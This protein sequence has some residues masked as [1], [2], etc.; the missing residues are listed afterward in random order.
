MVT[1]LDLAATH[2]GGYKGTIASDSFG[3]GGDGQSGLVTARGRWGRLSLTP[4]YDPTLHFQTTLGVADF[5]QYW[6]R[7]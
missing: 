3:D 2:P 5:L 6:R 4:F 7:R 1:A